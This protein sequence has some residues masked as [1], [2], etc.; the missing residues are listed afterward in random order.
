M[1]CS[2]CCRS[3]PISRSCCVASRGSSSKRLPNKWACP[4]PRSSADLGWQRRV[5]RRLRKKGGG[6]A[7]EAVEIHRRST[8][9]RGANRP[10]MGGNRTAHATG[11]ASG[12][13]H[14]GDDFTAGG[15]GIVLDHLLHV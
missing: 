13:D 3:K 4:S 2:T 7:N 8:S 5:W 9:H 15:A 6:L 14:V 12:R 10:R 1:P 11:A